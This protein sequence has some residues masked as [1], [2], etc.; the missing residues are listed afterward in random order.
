M[1][2][3]LKKIICAA[4]AAVVLAAGRTAQAGTVFG[5]IP[6]WFESSG[7]DNGVFTAH[8][9]GAEFQVNASGAE[10]I[11]RKPGASP[12]TVRMTFAGTGTGAEISAGD[13]LK[14]TINY[15]TGNDPA[16]WR[17]AVPACDSVHLDNI[18]PGVNVVYYGNNQ[19]LEYDFNLAAGVNPGTIVIRFDGAEKI[20]VNAD[21]ELVIQAG[22]GEIIQHKPLAYQT[23][24]GQHQK[25]DAGYQIVDAQTVTFK[26]GDFNHTLPLVVDPVLGYSTYFGGNYGESA[27]AVAVNTNDD[28]IFIAGQT[29]SS[30]VTNKIAFATNVV[31]GNSFSLT[32][33]FNGGD[34]GH[35]SDAYVAH[36]DS[37]GTNLLY[38][39]YI[40][41]TR[42]DLAWALAVDSAGHAFV[43]GGTDST[44][45]PIKNPLVY[46]SF[47]G[48]SIGGVN[49]VG[50]GVH[51]LDAFV[52]ELD[53]NGTSLVYSTYLGG[54]SADVAYGLAIDPSDN[55]YVT[56]YTLSSNFPV[57]LST[58]YQT[59]LLCTNNFYA[60]G[61]AFVAEISLVGTNLN[62][63]YS[64]Y[65]GG[66]NNDIANAICYSSYSNG[67]V[68][69]AGEADSTNFPWTNGL[70][71]SSFLNGNTNIHKHINASDAFVTAFTVNNTNLTMEYSTLLGGSNDDVA[72]GIAADPAGNAY[73]VGWTV[74]TNFPNTTNGAQLSSFVRTNTAGVGSITNAFLTQIT[75]NNTNAVVGYSQI[76]GGD[77]Y[78][79]ANGVARDPVSGNIFV[80]G[81]TTS[82][83]NDNAIGS[84]IYG[85]LRVTNSGASDAFV[86]VFRSDLSSLIYSANIGGRR[87]D[88]GNAIAVDTNGNAIV[89]GRTT[90][91]NFP[92]FGAWTTNLTG[93]VHSK[94]D[95]T[96]DA[97]VTRIL[98]ATSPVLQ[99]A[100]SG[101]NVLVF[102]QAISELTSSNLSIESTTNL[103]MTIQIITP[104][105][106]TNVV[107]N[108]NTTPPK[109]NT[110]VKTIKIT[111]D[112]TEF[113]TNWV[114]VTNPIPVLTNGDY[115]Y[116]FDPSN[117]VMFYRF[118]LFE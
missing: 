93:A 33:N 117:S 39:T 98:T 43:A 80:V 55:A 105:F 50:L 68:F 109:T 63:N 14:G 82:P 2:P 40:G 61:N 78:D 106:F 70:A 18:Y 26:V 94:M 87:A 23:V 81:T 52:T 110:T 6:L 115:T 20:Y 67:M 59:N 118:Y 17:T 28:S 21:G 83:T 10:F 58:A 100:H 85:S 112:V 89:T 73:V 4:I 84:D 101:T 9:R 29:F 25:V 90:S 15:L 69:V 114:T 76:F 62:L 97:F 107:V 72:T 108:T 11:L 8:T 1:N 65:L 24:S 102:W 22:G 41:G 3:C 30:Q 16:Q 91:T 19:N 74:S 57:T 27:V 77:I 37:T 92:A 7:P 51:P 66:T 35:Y 53:T 36:F 103:L 64:T 31:S 34:S 47:N 49:L 54:S 60:N 42:D 113:T 46:G 79:V 71:N 38:C 116:T 99:V 111:N 56:G 13:K 32:T 45:F 48:G 95:G 44:N 75:W 5:S 96:N 12:A 104:G 88:Y 86:T